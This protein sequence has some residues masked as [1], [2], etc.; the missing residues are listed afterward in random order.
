MMVE[1]A[2]IERDVVRREQFQPRDEIGPDAE[3]RVRLVLDQPAHRAKDLV[4]AKLLQ[5]A[6]DRRA[7]FERQRRHHA[8]QAR[9]DCASSEIHSASARCCG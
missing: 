5:I 4:V 3:V 6:R 9:L 7:L 1:D 2:D 8:V